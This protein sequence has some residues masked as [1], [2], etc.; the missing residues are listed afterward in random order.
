MCGFESY[1]FTTNTK[2]NVYVNGS[3]KNQ[4]TLHRT[5][6][7]QTVQRT[8]MFHVCGVHKSFFFLLESHD[9]HLVMARSNI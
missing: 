3:R 1:T 9:S 2:A 8:Y 4:A 5:Q 7:I 6:Q